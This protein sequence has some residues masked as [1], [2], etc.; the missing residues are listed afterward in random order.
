MANVVDVLI[1]EAKSLELRAQNARLKLQAEFEEI[2][3]RKLQVEAS[4]HATRSKIQRALNFDPGSSP[5]YYCPACW[6]ERGTRATLSPNPDTPTHGVLRCD[7]C[8]ARWLIP[9]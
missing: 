4:L 1:E 7:S 9:R 8:D 3:S 2:E 6:I 5:T